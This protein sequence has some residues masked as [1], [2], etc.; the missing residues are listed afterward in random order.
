MF[1]IN[2]LNVKNFKNLYQYHNGIIKQMSIPLEEP[3]IEDK[4][5]KN[6]PASSQSED[7]TPETSGAGFKK[8][9]NRMSRMNLNKSD[10]KMKKFISLNL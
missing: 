4:Y 2:H 5:R 3:I 9:Q 1:I 8:I 6:M 10:K 7:L